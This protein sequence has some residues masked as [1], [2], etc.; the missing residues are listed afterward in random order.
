MSIYHN[1]KEYK[2]VVTIEKYGNEPE[3]ITITKNGTYTAPTGTSYSPVNVNVQFET[4]ELNTTENG[5]FV[6]SKDGFSKVTVDVPQTELES[7]SVQENGTYNASAGKGYDTVVVAVPTPEPTLQEK[8]AT[9]NGDVTPDDGYDGLSKVTVNVQGGTDT[10][11][12]F[13]EG[14]VSGTLDMSNWD[15]PTLSYFC[16]DGYS[17]II[18]PNNTEKFHRVLYMDY[19]TQSNILQEIVFG[20][21]VKEL[22]SGFACLS[23]VN[24]ITFKTNDAPVNNY[25]FSNVAPFNGVMYVPML[26]NGYEDSFYRLFSQGWTKQTYGG[27]LKT[28]SG[29]DITDLKSNE[30]I[31][32]SNRDYTV[33][34]DDEE[35]VEK[36]ETATGAT[37]LVYIAEDSTKTCSGNITYNQ[38]GKDVTVNATSTPDTSLGD[39]DWD[40]VMKVRSTNESGSWFYL[41]N[42]GVITSMEVDGVSGIHT[43]F[44]LTTEPKLIK[45]NVSSNTVGMQPDNSTKFDYIKVRKGFVTYGS[46]WD[47]VECIIVESDKSNIFSNTWDL[48]LVKNVVFVSTADTFT[49][50]RN[51]N[52]KATTVIFIANNVT[53]N[54]VQYNTP[55]KVYVIND[56]VKNSILEQYPTWDVEVI[57]KLPVAE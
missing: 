14:N 4:D 18:F 50:T 45:F 10:L 52:D 42:D 21:N 46:G 35:G 31:N 15:C 3:P 36:T 40:F 27:T 41:N 24:K 6:P 17:K 37:S 39:L 55:K 56:T 5:V 38:W 9:V 32:I 7:L 28:V 34:Y 19:D 12:D 1:D 29:S 22:Y 20:E 44:R 23:G 8:T 51:I 33:V 26:N 47:N 2:G 48:F 13:F 11:K 16:N 30:Y 53:I 57:T 49:F 25:A 43:Q 54:T